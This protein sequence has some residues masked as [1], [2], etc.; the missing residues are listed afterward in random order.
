MAIRRFVRF[1]IY[2]QRLTKEILENPVANAN[3]KNTVEHLV[4]DS[5]ILISNQIVSVALCA[6]SAGK[7]DP[8]K[9]KTQCGAQ[10]DATNGIRIGTT[11]PIFQS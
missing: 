5:E 1:V 7:F 10:N 2:S 4:F 11:M 6:T 8:N 9:H 3:D